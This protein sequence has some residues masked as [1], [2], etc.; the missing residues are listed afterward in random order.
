[1]VMVTDFPGSC[2]ALNEGKPSWRGDKQWWSINGEEASCG[3]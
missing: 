2:V 1:M 3:W